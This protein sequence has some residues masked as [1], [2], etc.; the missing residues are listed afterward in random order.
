M[1]YRLTELAAQDL[2]DIIEYTIIKWGIGQSQKYQAA[3]LRVFDRLGKNPFALGSRPL[4][5]LAAGGRAINAEQHIVIYRN[6]DADVEILRI[7]H[8]RMNL[9][10]HKLL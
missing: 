7:L 10:L 5:D 2:V 6:V 3:F 4:S 8:Q 9:S 1:S